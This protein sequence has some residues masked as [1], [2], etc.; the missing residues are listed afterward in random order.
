MLAVEV[1]AEG[2]YPGGAHACES[3]LS[4][5]EHRR[6]GGVGDETSERVFG[7]GGAAIA[8]VNQDRACCLIDVHL[9][10]EIAMCWRQRGMG[11]INDS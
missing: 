5:G 9:Q 1:P 10:R 2:D 3:C 8:S 6:L 4:G 7:D 11:L